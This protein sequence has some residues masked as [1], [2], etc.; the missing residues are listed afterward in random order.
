MRIAFG[1]DHGGYKLK[2]ALVIYARE[3]GHAVRDFGTADHEAVD[4]PEYARLVG[5]ALVEKQ[6][7]LG[8]L[9]CRSGIGMSIAANKIKGI[10][11][12]VGYNEEVARLSRLHNGANVLCLGADFITET[13]ALTIFETFVNTAVSTDDRHQR[14]I[15]KIGALE[16]S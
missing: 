9:I 6:A 7:D 12:A 13:E 1:A 11:A 10:R 16:R 14:R 4:Y 15:A 5:N 2:D 3:K 8:V